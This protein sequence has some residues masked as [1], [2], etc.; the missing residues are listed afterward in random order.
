MNLLSSRTTAVRLG[1]ACAALLAG[2]AL[3]PRANAADVT[4]NYTITGRANVHIDT[5]DGSVRI[6][7]SDSKTV[8]FRVEYEGY[9]LDKNLHIESKQDGDRVPASRAIGDGPGAT[10]Q[11]SCTSKCRCPETEMWT[12]TRGMAR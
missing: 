3:V 4:K 2:V 7:T 9:E 12:R 8:Q 10:T 11:G 6:S 5:N 1:I